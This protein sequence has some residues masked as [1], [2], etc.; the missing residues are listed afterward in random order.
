MKA[1]N[2]LSIPAIQSSGHTTFTLAC[3][4]EQLKLVRRLTKAYATQLE[5]IRTKLHNY[6]PAD[7][8]VSQLNSEYI[9]IVSSWNR[10][11]RRLGIAVHGLWQV[12]FDCEEG[13]YSWQYPERKIRYF[14]EYGD[15]F[16]ERSLISPRK[17]FK[18]EQL[19]KK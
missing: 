12:G 4:A 14:I 19:F 13:W 1:T 16:A 9:E 10:K 8:R 15:T 17:E 3:A 11:M 6:V 7:P 2:S 18:P 5:P